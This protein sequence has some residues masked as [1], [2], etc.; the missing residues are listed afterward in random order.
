MYQANNL[1]SQCFPF[2]QDLLACYVMNTNSSSD[3]GKWKCVPQ[4][5]DYYECLHHSK[6]VS[7][8]IF[9]NR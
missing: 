4:R 7:E 6:E 5:D 8:P 2:W 9:I 1:L 3:E